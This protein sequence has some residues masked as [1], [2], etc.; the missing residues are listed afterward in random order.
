MR[1]RSHAA[2]LERRRRPVR[3][4]LGLLD[5]QQ[6]VEQLDR[7][8]LVEEAVVDQL[9]VLV[10]VPAMQTGAFRLLHGREVLRS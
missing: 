6:A 4:V 10:A 7:V 1:R 9:P 3:A 5:E 2:S 8:I